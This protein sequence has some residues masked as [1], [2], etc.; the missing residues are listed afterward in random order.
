MA[1]LQRPEEGHSRAA[2]G[3]I[4]AL[5]QA[6]TTFS[7]DVPVGKVTEVSSQPSM[8]T[9]SANDAPPDLEG[10]WPPKHSKPISNGS[11][12]ASDGFDKSHKD[13]HRRPPSSPQSAYILGTNSVEPASPASR[14]A[15]PLVV[16]KIED[17]V[18]AITASLQRQEEVTIPIKAK[19]QIVGSAHPAHSAREQGVQETLV[20]FPGRT[21]Q[22]AWRFSK[23]SRL[24]Q[25]VHG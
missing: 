20:R 22:E 9:A 5:F 12:R 16:S 15:N 6:T 25:R 10:C 18:R 4:V 11:P 21:A 17:Q 3:H 14:A 7:N 19:K 23:L 13:T 1:N 24:A 8:N 2:Q